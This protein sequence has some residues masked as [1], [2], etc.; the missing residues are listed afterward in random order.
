[1]SLE[2]VIGPMFS[3]KS[4]YALSYAR[5]YRA[6]GK[7]V[8]IVKPNIDSRYTDEHVM[9][10]HDH[11]QVPC[12]IWDI[13]LPFMYDYF[14]ND[15]CI[16]IEEAQFFHG[17]KDLVKFLLLE[18]KKHI[19]LVGLDGDASQNT[20]GELLSCIPLCTKLL[21]LDSYCSVCKDGTPASYTKRINEENINILDQV[22]VGGS[23]MYQAVCLKHLSIHEY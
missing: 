6:I 5:R 19:L 16:V 1:M 18:H 12:V 3:G 11:Q 15:D 23:E 10:S 13:N 2:I 17:L 14:I 7:R 22:C 21:K 20:F 8:L 4:T 9:I